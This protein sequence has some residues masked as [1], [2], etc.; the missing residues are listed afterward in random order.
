[1]S[2][3]LIYVL[4]ADTQFKRNHCFNRKNKGSEKC[5]R[6]YVTCNLLYAI[7]VQRLKFACLFFVLGFSVLQILSEVYM[8]N[9]CIEKKS[10]NF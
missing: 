4:Q 3:F 9:A 1:M 2:V 5:R 10:K 8:Y 6:K 7:L